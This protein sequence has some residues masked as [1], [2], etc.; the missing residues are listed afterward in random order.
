MSGRLLF[1]GVTT[2]AS[3]MVRVFPRWREV[4]DLGDVEL[5]PCDLPLHAPG[6]RYREVVERIARD[7]VAMGALVTTHKIDLF[8]AARDLFDE[9][10]EYAAICRETSCLAKR[11]GRLV[12][13]APDPRA[14]GRAIEGFLAGD[15]FRRTG[16]GVL[17]LG[18]G[19]AGVAI[20][21]YLLHLRPA[22]DR[23]A[24]VVLVDR[25]SERLA[26]AT[27]VARALGFERAL[28][29]VLSGG[30]AENSDLLRALPPKSL[31]INATGM[32][33]DTPGSPLTA[34]PP[35]PVG[36]VVWELNY[37]GALPFLRAAEARRERA[38]L[39]VEDGWEY[40]IQGWAANIE[41]VFDRPISPD[42]LDA[43]RQAAAF[44]RP[45]A[46]VRGDRGGS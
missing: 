30:A 34:D 43:L 14:A 10:E 39:Q 33:K 18:A 9:V 20:A 2:A 19:G 36:T 11:D 35:F 37:R 17:C 32:G 29:P 5:E 44:A 25:E 45:P 28:R 26:N 16:A 38:G 12:A 3:S 42:E 23:P 6:G 22:Q 21:L 8:R 4:L 31:A 13:S 7:P 15:H 40:F 41:Q 24:E 46:G 1:I 27:R